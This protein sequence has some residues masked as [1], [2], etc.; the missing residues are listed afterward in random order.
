M[1]KRLPALIAVIA[2]AVWLGNFIIK[3]FLAASLIAYGE[4]GASRDQAL[5]YSPSNPL[6]VAARAK[7]LLYRAD[8]PREEEAIAELQ[9]ATML[10]PRDYRFWLELGRAYEN[11]GAAD[12]AEKALRRAVQLAPRY[13]ETRWAFANFLLRAGKT[14]A[15]LNDLRE[16][17]ALSGGVAPYPDR[18][19]TMNALNTVAGVLGNDLGALR[20]I[21]PAD[22]VSQIYLAEFLAN[23]DALD[24]ALEIWRRSSADGRG[25]YRRLLFQLLPATQS[26]GRFAEMRGIWQS[27]MTLEGGGLENSADN[28]MINS[29]FERPPLSDKYPSLASPPTGFDWTMRH[30]PEVAARRDSV[31]KKTG[32]YSLRLTF[33]SAMN[34]EFENISQLVLVEP[35]RTY[36]LSY[37]VKSKQ[38]PSQEP[39]YVEIT[40][41][42]DAAIFNLRSPAPSG[43][44]EWIEQ[45]LVFSAPENTRAIRLT[46]RS[47]RLGVVDRL[48]IGEVWFDD[49]KLKLESQ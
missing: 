3:N 26:K 22:N 25:H 27:L 9:R 41:A 23:H 46:I 14:E 33:N 1:F 35:S 5:V 36:R 30:H 16:A 12:R 40:D 39:P 43:T 32:S 10:A 44:T 42:M 15:A 20:G 38:I 29:G 7:F 45:S 24:Q 4:D 19:A 13:F 49:F 6:V 2:L 37:F 47:P 48:R 28:L 34:S 18:A 21:L 17:V 31:E 8:P 11:T